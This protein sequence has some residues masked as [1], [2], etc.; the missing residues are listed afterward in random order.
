ME[1]GV[2]GVVEGSEASI[3][4]AM[5]WLIYRKTGAAPAELLGHEWKDGGMPQKPLKSTNLGTVISI[6]DGG[7][8]DCDDSK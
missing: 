2:D 5:W 6:L 7:Y 8:F 1:Y 4:T 3:F